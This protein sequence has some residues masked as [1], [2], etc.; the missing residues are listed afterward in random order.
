MPEQEGSGGACKEGN[1]QGAVGVDPAEVLQEFEGR[2]DSD[3]ERK[4]MRDEDQDEG[5]V[6]PPEIPEIGEGE[7]REQGEGDL[8]DGN[9]NRYKNTVEE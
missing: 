9:R 6:L 1:S 3:R 4:H 8:S 7:G 5:E 2:N